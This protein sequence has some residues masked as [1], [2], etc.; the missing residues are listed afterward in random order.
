MRMKSIFN[1]N[2]YQG[3][4]V[5]FSTLRHYVPTN[6][7]SQHIYQSLTSSI[8][9]ISHSIHRLFRRTMTRSDDFKM[10]AFQATLNESMFTNLYVI[11]NSGLRQNEIKVTTL[12][13]ST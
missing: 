12:A 7:G 6:C 11:A 3:A 4:L 13:D 9:T 1:C 2:S 10:F 8:R 5:R